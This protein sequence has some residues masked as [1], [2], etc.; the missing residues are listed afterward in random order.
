VCVCVCVCVCVVRDRAAE[1]SSEKDLIKER[2]VVKKCGH[3]HVI[4]YIR[5]T[6]NMD[7]IFLKFNID[8]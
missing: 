5:W 3:I 1:V 7:A 4:P 2:E 8:R 6:L